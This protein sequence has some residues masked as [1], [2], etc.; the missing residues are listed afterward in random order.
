MQVDL[1]VR[2]TCRLRPGVPGLSETVRVRSILGRFLEHARVYYFGG[3]GEE[4]YLIGSA[5]LMKRNLESRVEV[6]LPVTLPKL[7]ARLRTAL[8][9]QLADTRGAW[10]MRADGS[11]VRSTGTGADSQQ[12]LIADAEAR[13]S[14]ADAIRARAPTAPA[15]PRGR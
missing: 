11:Y 14:A 15:P 5:D 9:V 4:T 8:D 7:R 12:Q 3:G 1:I 6:V 10:L 2:D 13:V